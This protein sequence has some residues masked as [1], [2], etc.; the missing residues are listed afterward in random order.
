MIIIN[1][2][3]YYKCLYNLYAKGNIIIEMV[4][5]LIQKTVLVS[6]FII[7]LACRKNSA[8]TQIEFFEK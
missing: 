3:W 7:I 8:T 1:I 5:Y 2:S 6:K 4:L